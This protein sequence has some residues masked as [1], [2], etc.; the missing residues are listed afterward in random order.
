MYWFRSSG[1][2]HSSSTKSSAKVPLREAPLP[3]SSS[4]TAEYYMYQF[5]TRLLCLS[6]VSLP[7]SSDRR[8]DYLLRAG[9]PH[10][11]IRPVLVHRVCEVLDILIPLVLFLPASAATLLLL[12]SSNSRCLLIGGGVRHFLIISR[13]FLRL[14]LVEGEEL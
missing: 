7:P 1:R 4:S 6:I 10:H 5:K 12:S 14:S 2:S 3:P 9:P 13:R 8:P 11:F